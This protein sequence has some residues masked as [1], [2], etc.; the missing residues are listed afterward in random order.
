MAGVESS[1]GESI[2]LEMR[3]IGMCH[4]VFA[5]KRGVPRQGML[6][7]HTLG[8]V[9][10]HT[11]ISGV[12]L[13]GL[14]EF[15]HV[16]VV[17]VFSRNTNKAKVDAWRSQNGSGNVTFPAK[18]RPP[19][20]HGQATGLFST[21]TPHRP[22]PIGLTLARVVR[23]DAKNRRVHLA[24]LDLCDMTPVLDLKPIAPGDV[25]TTEI[26]YAPWVS[27]ERDITWDIKITNEAIAKI[28]QL[29]SE[30]A[31]RF[32][33]S[34]ESFTE[35]IRDVLGLDVRAVHQ[36][37]GDA[38][39]KDEVHRCALDGVQVCFKVMV[40]GSAIE[41][42]DAHRYNASKLTDQ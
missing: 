8:V 16:W 23:V 9:Q 35:G 21:R 30:G 28:A 2:R 19:L 32:Y 7:P 26:Q 15:S 12:A 27:A 4:T 29:H 1:G 10:L 42:F 25:P 5:S 6:A 13:E 36:G 33:E 41:V 3:S 18:I 31:M 34:P 38:T 20:L 17:F 40:Q 22:N 14:E 11:D 24:G 37:R 39:Q